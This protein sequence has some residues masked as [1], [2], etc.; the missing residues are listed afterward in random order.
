MVQ[1]A[2]ANRAEE[3]I[4]PVFY[5]H[6]DPIKIPSEDAMDTEV[7]AADTVDAVTRAL[8]CVEG[9]YNLGTFPLGSHPELWERVWPWARFFGAHNSR[10]PDASTEDTIRARVFSIVANLSGTPSKV[11]ST[12]EIGVLTAQVWGSHFRDPNQNPNFPF[13]LALFLGSGGEYTLDPFIEGAGCVD[14]L[15]IMVVKLPDYLLS[16][17]SD[18]EGTTRCLGSVLEFCRRAEDQAWLSALRSH[19]FIAAMVS[20]LLFAER[21]PEIP[22]IAGLYPKLFNEAWPG[23]VRV[24]AL[25]SGYTHVVEAIDAGYIQLIVSIAGRHV[26]WLESRIVIGVLQPA[27]VYYPV[28]AALE[29]TLPLIQRATSAPTFISCTLY[30]DWQ[31]FNDL[32]LDRLEVKRMF[33]SG[34]HVTCRACDNLECGKILK[35]TDFKRC[36][37]C[38]HHHYCSKECQIKDWRTGHRESCPKIHLSEFH[39]PKYLTSR[40]RAFL[41]FLVARDYEKHKLQIFLGWIRIHHH[42]ESLITLFDYNT[43]D[44]EIE[45]RPREFDGD[46]NYHERVM[47]SGRRMHALVIQVIAGQACLQRWLLTIRSS[48]SEVHEALC[49][50]SPGLPLP[51]GEDAL[52]DLSPDV[53]DTVTQLIEN[54]CPRIQEIVA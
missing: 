47:R 18:L 5:H 42:G 29:R 2:A 33:D 20:V 3:R 28:L 32:V 54:I 19:K 45:M 8:L 40:D 31:E 30:P 22:N 49:Q 35:K 51:T 43:G 9:L 53:H 38:E 50:L 52:S 39:A 6:L 48:A 10:I 26:D 13:R 46:R 34:E 16:S 4:L 41:R 21:L 11:A 17:G 37:G 15:A 14:A 12:P 36:A 7:L 25:D 1:A 23:F 27:T 24:S 44:L